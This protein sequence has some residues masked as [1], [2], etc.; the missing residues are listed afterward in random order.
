MRRA[1]PVTYYV[2]IIA[3]PSQ[4]LYTGVTNNLE[5]RIAEH[6]SGVGSAFVRRYRITRLVHVE[7]FDDIRTAIAREKQIKGLRRSKKISLIGAEN[8]G[9][10]DLASDVESRDSSLR[11]E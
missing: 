10:Q 9:W 2:Y 6:K 1:Q 8:S 3:S 11:S 7:R 4:T 5:R